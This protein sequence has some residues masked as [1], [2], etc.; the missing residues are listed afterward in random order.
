MRANP[1]AVLENLKYHLELEQA[2]HR[3]GCSAA[4]ALGEGEEPE[5]MRRCAG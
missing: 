2:H 5:D 4:M 3:A 1:P